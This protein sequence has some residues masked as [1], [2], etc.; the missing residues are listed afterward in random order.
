MKNEKS[1]V[2]FWEA[3]ATQALSGKTIREVRYMDDD[4]RDAFGWS[5]RGLVIIFTDGSS[6]IPMSD[7][8][9][10]EAGAVY[11]SDANHNDMSFPVI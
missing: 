3:R 7:D 1:V 11:G 10:N 6:I 9:G 4:E 2:E 8:E 5:K